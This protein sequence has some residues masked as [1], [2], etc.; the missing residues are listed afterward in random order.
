MSTPSQ[1]KGQKRNKDSP[2]IS[3]SEFNSH[4]APNRNAGRDRFPRGGGAGGNYGQM[5]R[6][7]HGFRQNSCQNDR[8]PYRDLGR[9]RHSASG[10]EQQ[11]EEKNSNPS[12][13]TSYYAGAKCL[14]PP[15]PSSLPMPPKS[16][17]K[18][19]DSAY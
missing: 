17:L 6:G 15:V 12:M 11:T 7:D 9:A 5:S 3:N 8:T 16:W 1:N 10:A 2:K 18:T 13:A 4:E 14:S 19:N